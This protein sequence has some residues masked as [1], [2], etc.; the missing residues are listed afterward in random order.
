MALH[1]DI[2]WIGRQWAVTGLGM[3]LIDQK[4]KGFFDIEVPQLWD[5]ALIE[6]TRAKEWLNVADFDKGLE[7]ARKRFPPGSVTSPPAAATPAQPAA[8][9]AVPEAQPVPPLTS[10]ASAPPIVAAPVIT[11]IKPVRKAPAP[12]QIT[13]P[14]EPLSQEAEM[15]EPAKSALGKF[16]MQFLGYGKFI[17][18]WRVRMKE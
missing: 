7:V 10:V 5:E 18:P 9:A 4:L 15:I 3:Q 8:L 17:R 11:S 6:T 14:A 1:R 13:T 16:Q 12:A 2:H